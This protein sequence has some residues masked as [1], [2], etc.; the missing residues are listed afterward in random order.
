M[1]DGIVIRQL[2]TMA[3][4]TAMSEVERLVWETED[5]C[6]IHQL[7]SVSKNGGILLGAYQK[8][9]MVGMLHS[10]P[11]FFKGQAYLWSDMMGIRS[12]WRNMGLGRRL[13]EMQAEKALENGYR[14]I[15][16]TYD[17]LETAN[18][19]LNIGK[20]GAICSSYVENRH[21]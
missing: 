16:W 15:A 11:A 10:L 7:F 20:L 1:Q 19:Y 5:T 14:L 17:P 13:K 3:E 21:H 2:V 6:C 4:I 8:G 9:E 12:K 18:G